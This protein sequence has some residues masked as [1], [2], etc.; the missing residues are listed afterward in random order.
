MTDAPLPARADVVVVGAGVAGLSAAARLAEAGRR[1]VVLEEA[2]RLGGR[3]TAFEDRE[4]GD[5]VDNGQHVLFGCYRD[6]YAFLRRIGSDTLAPLQP[7]LALTMAGGD[8][9][10]RRLQCPRLPPPWHLAA[11]VLRWN[12][13]SWRDRASILRIKPFLDAARRGS[14]ED[15][16]QAVPA[17]QTVTAWLD[18]RGQSAGIRRWLWHPLAIAA[19]NQHPDVAAAR[20]FVRVLAEL[21][22]PRVEASAVGL[23]TV[24]LDDLYAAPAR[25]FIEARGGVVATRARARLSAGESNGESVRV[26]VRDQ[27]IDAPAVVCAVAWHA[28]ARVF[29][30]A[31]PPAIADV[32]ASASA[33]RASPIV[34]V[35]LWLDGPAFDGPFVGLV[36][37]P[38]QWAFDKSAIFGERAGHL[39]LV[40]S[41]A[42]ALAAMDAP[43]IVDRA[44]AELR[45]ALPATAARRVLRSVVVKERRAT[46]S[47]AP[48]EPARP[49]TRTSLAG[50]YLAGDWIE[51]G[52][53]GTIE[54]AARSGHLAAEAV[55]AGTVR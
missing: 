31:V 51:T 11:G 33:R 43:S 38:I 42:D 49:G 54:S 23:P 19:L 18:A 39:S 29:D 46:F 21:F 7:R 55:L 45:R 3:T 20:P 34:T 47:L 5:R 30:P 12:A 35:N 15:V 17:D 2:P 44:V 37:G 25:R 22:G 26:A 6:T 1:V 14:P 10:A 53:P 24:P 16:V 32:A 41:A 27:F 50:L 8:G 28:L 48:G 36:D 40:A 13:L 52:L 4:S 9:R